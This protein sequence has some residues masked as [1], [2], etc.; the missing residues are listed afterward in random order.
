MH[1]H[2]PGQSCSNI[3]CSSSHHEERNSYYKVEA[4]SKLLRESDIQV[5]TVGLIRNLNDD[6]GF[7]RPS[8]RQAPKDLLNDVAQQ[9]RG[10]VFFPRNNAEIQTA[11]EEIAKNLR[12]RLV[13]GFEPMRNKPG[14]NKVEIKL[15]RGDERLNLVTKPAYWVD[16]KKPD[17]QMKKKS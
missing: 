14:F 13:I 7:R 10:L 16:T 5:F 6:A 3:D 9:S 2:R 15:T 8:P 4:L 17:E 11:V 1:V 12:E